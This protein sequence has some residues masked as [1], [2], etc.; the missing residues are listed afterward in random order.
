MLKPIDCKCVLT[1]SIN[2][3]NQDVRADHSQKYIVELKMVITNLENDLQN[4]HYQLKELKCS[5]E[6]LIKSS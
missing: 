3:A 5:A 6:S 2:R 1:Q 4:K